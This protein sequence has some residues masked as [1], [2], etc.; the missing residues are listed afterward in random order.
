MMTAT[1]VADLLQGGVY[2]RDFAKGS[3]LV[4]P[5]T[6]PV[7]VMLGATMQEVIP[8]GGGA[9]DTTGDTPGSITMMPVTSVTVPAT[10]A[11]I[12]LN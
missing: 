7:T 10:G 5:S 4:N 1:T 3:A 11:M 8:Q 6:S 2:R 12:L 9:I